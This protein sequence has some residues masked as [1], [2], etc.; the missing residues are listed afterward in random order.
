MPPPTEHDTRSGA[1]FTGSGAYNRARYNRSR[2]SSGE[3]FED[4]VRSVHLKEL[5]TLPQPRPR[6]RRW[7]SFFGF[8]L[9]GARERTAI[10]V[11]ATVAAPHPEELRAEEGEQAEA[12]ALFPPLLALLRPLRRRRR[13]RC[14]RL[15][16]TES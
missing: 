1:N 6:P 9:E 10:A 3:G 12:R 11:P 15:T 2:D 4:E 5:M 14:S 13:G 8:S 7:K 16:G